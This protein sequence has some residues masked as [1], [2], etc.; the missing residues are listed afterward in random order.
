MDETTNIILIIGIVLGL[1]AL[2]GSRA[3]YDWEE[4]SHVPQWVRHASSKGGV[5]FK[6]KTYVYKVLYE[7]MEQGVYKAHYYRKLRR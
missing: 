4:V 3:R 2:W 5:H 1:A 6:G 7:P